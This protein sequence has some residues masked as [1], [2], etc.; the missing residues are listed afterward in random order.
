MTSRLRRIKQR[1]SVQ[2]LQKSPRM[3]CR[4]SHP[5]HYSF[6]SS[7]IEQSSISH[8]SSRRCILILCRWNPSLHVGR[9]C[10][11]VVRSLTLSSLISST[12]YTM[13]SGLQ[14]V[15]M[16][17]TRQM[18]WNKLSSTQKF[19]MSC[20]V[21][22]VFPSTLTDSTIVITINQSDSS[23]QDLSLESWSTVL[24]KRMLVLLSAD[25]LSLWTVT[26]C[27]L[28]W[29]FIAKSDRWPSSV[30]MKCSSAYQT[31]NF[32]LQ[33][34]FGTVHFFFERCRVKRL[35]QWISIIS[36][37]VALPLCDCVKCL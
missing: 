2:R 7:V 15:Q 21:N 17:P 28:S 6:D 24:P 12:R 30:N 29:I 33:S 14:I 13:R 9:S 8:H 3:E 20:L 22:Y 18:Y 4:P 16:R 34:I 31:S 32:E 36:S 26:R 11:H 5:F 1:Y 37:S 10:H 27:P 35:S 25:Q 23:P 19:V